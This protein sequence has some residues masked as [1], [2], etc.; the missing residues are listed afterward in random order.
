MD[1]LKTQYKDLP[2]LTIKE[3]IALFLS[4]LHFGVRSSSEEWQ[5][6]IKDYFYNFFI[7]YVKNLIESNP[8]NSYILMVLGDV[9]DDRK[10]IDINV[11]ELAIDIF[12]DLSKII[13]VIIINGNHDLSKKT[14]KG[15]SSLRS[16]SNIPN[17][18]VIKE[19]MV[20][21]VKQDK[22]IVSS[23]I[24]IPYLGNFAEENAIL[25]LCS[26]KCKYA[27]M[28]TDIS[29]MKYDNGMQ[30]MGAVDAELFKGTILSGHIHKRQSDK[31]V[32][33]IG[34]PYQ[35]KRSDIDNQKGVYQLNLINDDITFYPNMYSPIFHKIYIEDFMKM[36]AAE[37][38]KFLTNNY[39]YIILNESDLR[40]Y[41]KTDLYDII[42]ISSA[43]N[44]SIIV[45]KQKTDDIIDSEDYSEKTIEELINESINALDVEDAV[46]ERLQKLSTQYLTVAQ[47]EI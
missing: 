1:I 25:R 34:S 20:I 32:I 46:K 3:T 2:S 26:D 39:N 13:N 7:P 21:K 14:N 31:N 33:Y 10:S 4:D 41:K 15:N 42:N 35:L 40:K 19:P 37:R 38:D 9:Y 44:V 5:N 30:I 18:N 22:R 29:K 8:D 47:N 12:E 11:N 6:N 16:L 28:H 36:N 43:K 45:N 23:I 27:L 17:V 24:A